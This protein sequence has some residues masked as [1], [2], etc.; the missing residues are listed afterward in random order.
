[1]WTIVIGETV[2]GSRVEYQVSD[3]E[4]GER[5]VSHDFENYDDAVGFKKELEA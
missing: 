1:M 2:D 3:G 5:T 4:V